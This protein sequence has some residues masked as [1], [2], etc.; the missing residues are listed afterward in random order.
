MKNWKEVQEEIASDDIHFKF[1]NSKNP[2]VRYIHR[3]RLEIISKLI[4]NS[5][6]LRV[7]EV[8]C[9]DGFVLKALESKGTELY[10]IDISPK[11]VERA[12]RLVPSAKVYEVNAET[13]PFENN[14]FNVTVCSE[15]LEHIENPQKA[16]EEMIR[17]TK[18]PG[19]MIISV[20][21]E[22]N[23]RIARLLLLRFP[24]RISDHINKF[25]I[26]E[27]DSMFGRKHKQLLTIPVFLPTHFCLTCIVHYKKCAI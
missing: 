17:V 1:Y 9:G 5:K 8:G 7:L 20:P 18:E 12:K 22:L 3:K 26:K 14:C 21:N 27:L 23:W 25:S 24:L 2:F 11:R 4:D 19:D 13:L 6:G 15:A 10:G 16:V